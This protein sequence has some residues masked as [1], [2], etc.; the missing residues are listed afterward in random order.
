MGVDAFESYSVYMEEIRRNT[1]KH[2]I[3]DPKQ[4]HLHYITNYV[5]GAKTKLWTI[6]IVKPTIIYTPG[7]TVGAGLPS[8]Y[9][10]PMW[11]LRIVG[12]PHIFGF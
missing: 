6:F 7:G 2:P 11:V 3:K 10:R 5:F 12:C 8:P 1:Q 9:E 4:K